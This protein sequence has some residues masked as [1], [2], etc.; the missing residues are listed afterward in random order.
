MLQTYTNW[1]VN[2]YSTVA[3]SWSCIDDTVL[4][5]VC[6]CVCLCVCVVCVVCVCVC[7]CVCHCVCVSVC[8]CV[9]YVCVCVCV[10]VC[11]M[12]VCVRLCV[13]HKGVT[14]SGHSMTPTPVNHTVGPPLSFSLR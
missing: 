9:Y 12:C 3:Q 1:V 8:R 13:P 2:C 11:M 10:C 4:V 7:M 5:F 14:H 6:V